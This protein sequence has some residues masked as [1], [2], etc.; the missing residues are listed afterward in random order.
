[1]QQHLV[2]LA[3]RFRLARSVVPDRDV[4][5]A[6]RLDGVAA[7]LTD[8]P[9]SYARFPQPVEVAADDGVLHVRV[10]DDGLGGA[11]VASG[12]GLIGL[13]DRVEALGGQFT[14][15]SPAGAGTSVRVALPIRDT[16]P[17]LLLGPETHAP[18]VAGHGHPAHPQPTRS[19]GD[20]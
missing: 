9:T 16:S 14:L 3:L 7:E 6:E 5:P 20:R 11:G 18:D 10:R 4:E 2:S 19:A 13:T 12:S 15:R 8:V 17:P 1:M